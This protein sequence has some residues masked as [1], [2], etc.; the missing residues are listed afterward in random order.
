MDHRVVPRNRDG[1]DE[2]LAEIG[3]YE[4]DQYAILKS[5]SGA[6]VTDFFWIRFDAGETFYHLFGEELGKGYERN[7]P[8]I[9]D[10]VEDRR[11]GKG[12]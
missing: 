7:F 12:D 8:D 9:Y 2:F 5:N 4:Y 6:T 1:I 10:D 3:I 11:L